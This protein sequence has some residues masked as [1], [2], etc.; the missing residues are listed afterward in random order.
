MSFISDIINI[1]EALSTIC[2][3]FS[4]CPCT[5]LCLTPMPTATFCMYMSSC[6]YGV[7]CWYFFCSYFAAADAPGTLRFFKIRWRHIHA[8]FKHPC[9]LFA[10]RFCYCCWFFFL[11]HFRKNKTLR[12]RTMRAYCHQIICDMVCRIWL[13]AETRRD[14]MWCNVLCSVMLCLAIRNSNFFRFVRSSFEFVHE[15]V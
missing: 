10:S 8:Y 13:V 5:I 7:G 6:Y 14:A 9:A 15:N 1:R 2:F 3:L 12:I 11:L 4:F